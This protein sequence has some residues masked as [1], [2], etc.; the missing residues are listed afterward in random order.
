MAPLSHKNRSDTPEEKMRL[1]RAALAAGNH[2]AAMSL[3]ESIKDTVTWARQNESDPGKPVVDAKT[4]T[5]VA[6]LPAAWAQWA[7]GWQFFKS[8]TLFEGGAAA[9]GREAV[10]LLISFRADQISDPRR[11]IRVVQVDPTDGRLVEVPS[12]VHGD[13]RRRAERLCQLVFFAAVPHHGSA[14]YLVFYGNAN[15]E[16]PHY[17]SALSTNGEGYA[18]EIENEHYV[19]KLSRQHGQLERLR[20]KREH[21]LELYAGGKGHGEPPS[22]DWAHDYVD[23]GGFQKLR[24]K[25]WASCPNFE[26]VRGPLCVQVRRWGFPHGPLHPAFTPSRIHMDITYTFYAGLPYFFKQSRFEAL[27]DVQMGTLRDDEWVFSGYSFTRTLWIDARGRLHEGPVPKEHAQDVWGVGFYHDKSRDAFIALWLEHDAEKLDVALGNNG[28]GILHYFGHGQLWCR[29]PAAGLLIKAG[30]TFT[31]KN[32]YL[33][34]GFPE[35]DG[36]ATVE[37]LRQRLVQPL[38]VAPVNL[39]R[40]GEPVAGASLAREGETVRTAPLKKAIWET[41]REVQDEQIYAADANIVDMGYV[42]DVRVRAGTVHVVISMP[43][44][45]RPIYDYLVFQ[46]GGRVEEGIRERL[47]RLAGID[48]VVVELTWNPPWSAARATDAGRRVLGL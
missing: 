45:G 48:Q 35:K 10:D 36:T 21:G 17:P 22:I 9:R 34:A 20:Y 7:E 15:A 38:D 39:P 16:L 24:V 25:D 40:L 46:G 8:L 3:A 33:A 26:V 2:V 5:P 18:L 31:Q 37:N 44:P 47:L 30:T 11:E 14:N 28:A 6:T 43:H 13:R 23:E 1:L 29:V 4:F 19:A 12:Q 41:L 42:H 27:K 32:A